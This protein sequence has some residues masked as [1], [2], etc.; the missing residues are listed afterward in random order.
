MISNV[1][2]AAKVEDILRNNVEFIS[3]VQ[4]NVYYKD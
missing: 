2:I 3:K 1:L 4:D